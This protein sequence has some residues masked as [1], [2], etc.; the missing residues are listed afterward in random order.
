M[1]ERQPVFADSV[2]A[3]TA[4]DILHAHAAKTGAAVY[5]FCIMPDHVHLVLGPAESCD[6]VTFVGQFKN[7]VLRAAWQRGLQGSFWQAS[8]WDHLVRID[9]GLR[10]SVNYVLNNPVRQGLVGDRRDYPFAG[11]LVFQLGSDE[12]G[13][14]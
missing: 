14:G 8:F 12:Q 3:A 11:S 1:R 4:V 6:I 7:L 10:D 2:L 9:E 5:G 13:R